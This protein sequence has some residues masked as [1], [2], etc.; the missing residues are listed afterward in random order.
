MS[1]GPNMDMDPALLELKDAVNLC[2]EKGLVDIKN[3]LEN[4]LELAKVGLYV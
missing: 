3:R 1:K 4:V 2:K